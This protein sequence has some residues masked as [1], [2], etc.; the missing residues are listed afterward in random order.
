MVLLKL[1]ALMNESVESDALVMS[2]EQR[3]SSCGALALGDDAVV[4][5]AEAELV[6]LFVEEECRVADVFYLHP[7][8]H[9]A[10]DGF[11]VLVVDV[12]AL[13]AVDLLNGVDQIGLRVFFAEDGQQ[14]VRVE[15]AVDQRLAGL[16][17]FAFLH[18][19]VHAA[20]DRVFLLRFAV[21]ALDV[22]LAQAF[23]DFAVLHDAV[24]FADDGGVARLASLEEFDDARQSSGDVLGLRGFARNLREHVSR[25]NFVAILHHQ[26]RAG[27]HE[28]FLAGAAGGV[29][30][31]NRGRV[32]FIARRQRD[33]QL[34]QTRDFVHLFLDRDAGLQV[35][36]LDRAS[37]F[38][39]DRERVGIP[40]GQKFAELDG[41]VFLDL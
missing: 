18:V 21:F 41:L 33:D 10:D 40:F 9:L 28:I 7:A 22:N 38:G 29:T 32:L 5:L 30:H 14:I 12:D 31:L 24:D 6:H 13:Q 1:A 16:D 3:T 11:D 2:E 4:F 25:L 35:L 20:N 26:V 19:D 36:E 17:V 37:S 8:H 15:R 27:R 34:R 23:A 39:E